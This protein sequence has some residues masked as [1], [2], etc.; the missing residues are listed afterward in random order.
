M[1]TPPPPGPY[2]QQPGLQPPGYGQPSGYGHP[3]AYGQPPSY[4]QPPAYGQP[5]GYGQP[6]AY[7]QQP[8]GPGPQPAYGQPPAG[9]GQMP[10]WGQ[11]PPPAKPP[12]RKAKIRGVVVGLGLIGVAVGGLFAFRALTG[13]GN[14]G[15]N[16]GD[17]LT[18]QHRTVACTAADANWKVVARHT[19]L[20]STYNCA[21]QYPGTTAYDSQYRSKKKTVKYRLCISPLNAAPKPAAGGH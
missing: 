14:K 6:P 15:A 5:S 1:S 3:P 11:A 17:C 2:G 13:G 7:G 19:G 10:A 12:T 18:T 4:G 16:V 21:Q 8:P 20:I 9:E